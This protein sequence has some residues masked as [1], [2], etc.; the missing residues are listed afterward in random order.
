MIYATAVIVLMVFCPS[1]LL[2]VWGRL[3]DRFFAQ[4]RSRVPT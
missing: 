2:G 3:R 1:G 4:A